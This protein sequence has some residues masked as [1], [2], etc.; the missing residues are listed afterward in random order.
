M[1]LLL[2][3]ISAL[4][5]ASCGGGGG[6]GSTTPTPVQVANRAPV[7][8]DPG[9]LTVLEGATSIATI[10]ASD[11]DNNSLIFT[12]SSGDD[13]ALLSITSSGVLS[14]VAA[15]DFETPGDVGSNNVYD[16]TVKVSDGTLTDR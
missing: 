12:I 7:L 13:Q 8:A 9:A 6:G 14:F 3:S 16:I 15:P 10:S 2:L 11:P 5:V 4:I 1:R